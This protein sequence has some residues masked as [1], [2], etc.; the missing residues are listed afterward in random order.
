VTTRIRATI[1][2]LARAAGKAEIVGGELV[3]MAPTGGRPGYAGDEI[4]ASLREYARRTRRGRAVGD[5]QAFRV[6]LPNRD[7][8]SPDAALYVGPACP[9]GDPSERG[10]M[11]SRSMGHASLWPNGRRSHGSRSDTGIPASGAASGETV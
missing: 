2:D 6:T 1:E 3:L 9:F 8:F 11:C 5:N 10:L 7:C 4:F